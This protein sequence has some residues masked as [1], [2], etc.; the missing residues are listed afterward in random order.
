[1]NGYVG[2]DQHYMPANMTAVPSSSTNGN[3]QLKD[4]KELLNI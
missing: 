3:G 1:M 4:L 2:G